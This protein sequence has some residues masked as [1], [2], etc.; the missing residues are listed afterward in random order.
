MLGQ[1]ASRKV[2]LFDKHYCHFFLGMPTQVAV[3]PRLHC[4]LCSVVLCSVK[5]F[6]ISYQGPP[7]FICRRFLQILRLVLDGTV[8]EANG[9][10]F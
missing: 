3:I 2:R 6:M 8:F 9:W 10:Q 1:I 7:I 4:V 5:F